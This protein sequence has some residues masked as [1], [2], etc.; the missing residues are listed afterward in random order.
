MY[1]EVMHQIRDVPGDI[2]EFGVSSG[3]SFKSFVRLA[4]VYNLYAHPVSKRR[5]IGFDS[6]EGLPDLLPEDASSEGWDQPG[7]MKKGGFDASNQYERI[8]AFCALHPIASIEKGWFSDSVK[9]FTQRNEHLSVAL[10]H[11]DCDLYQST[12]DA[13]APFLRIMPPGGVILFD[14]V[15]HPQFPGEAKAFW[16]EFQGMEGFEFVRVGAMPWKWYLRRK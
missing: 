10:L 13:L 9:D 2:I 7:D 1:A 15:F 14:E 8:K 11:I 4:E 5:V 16:D 12:R 3:V 6:F